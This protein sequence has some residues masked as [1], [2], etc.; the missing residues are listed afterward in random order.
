M[1]SNVA[2]KASVHERRIAECEAVRSVVIE[3]DRT[4]GQKAAEA[5]VQIIQR[6]SDKK[7]ERR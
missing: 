3:K 6:P 7:R 1:R 2:P 4:I 5:E